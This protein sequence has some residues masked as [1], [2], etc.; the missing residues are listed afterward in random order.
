MVH[1]GRTLDQREHAPAGP[2]GKP[3]S[4][5]AR[6]SIAATW[7]APQPSRPWARDALEV[8]RGLSS[9]WE[10]PAWGDATPGSTA[11]HCGVGKERH[12]SDTTAGTVSG[13]PGRGPM[14]APRIGV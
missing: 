9:C 2:L 8:T 5:K 6:A 1:I 3:L 11:Q 10:P 7:F 12:A 4:C 13:H 14:R